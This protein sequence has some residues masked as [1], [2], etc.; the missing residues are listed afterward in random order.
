M[1]G[2]W[3]NEPAEKIIESGSSPL[4]LHTRVVSQTGGGPEKTILNSPRYLKKHGYDSICVYFRDPKDEGFD[5]IVARAESSSAP[6][7]AVDDQGA[8]DVGILRRLKTVLDLV[9][10]R[11]LIWHGHDYKSNLFG[12]LLRQRNPMPVVTTV[13]G[14]VLKTWKTPLYYA[15]DRWCLKRCDEVICVSTDLYNRCVQVGVDLTHLHEIDNAIALDDYQRKR[16]VDE[17]KNRIKL[18]SGRKLIGAVGRLSPEKGFDVLISALA[19]LTENGIDAGL[20]IVGSGPEEQNLKQLIEQCDLGDRVLL[21]GYAIDPRPYFEA[22]D[23]FALSSRR[24]G[25][26]NVLLEAMSLSIPVVA[27]NIAGVPKLIKDK[28]NGLLVRHSDP[29]ELAHAIES[30]LRDSSL[31]SK[32]AES[33]LNTIQQRFCFDRRIERVTEIYE[34]YAIKKPLTG[35]NRK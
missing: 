22:M 8:L 3:C 19:K 20:V 9:N 34:S 33:G 31:S 21:T 30:I 32:L 24:E 23:V 18:R 26:P 25:L 28:Q 11:P 6:L 2:I 4:V 1:D 5:S 35:E 13:H 29:T 16:T 17:A 14:W 15:V 27:T 10:N 7:I 12:L